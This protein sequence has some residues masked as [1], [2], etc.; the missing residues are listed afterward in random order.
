MK[1]YKSKFENYENFNVLETNKPFLLT[2]LEKK[3]WDTDSYV[4]QIYFTTP[5]IKKMN[6]FCLITFRPNKI[7]CDFLNL[8]I[9]YKMF[10]IVDDNNFDLHD[11]KNNYKNI[12]FIQIEEIKCMNHGFIDT[13]FMINKLV[14]GWD[15]A[16]YYFSI[17]YTDYE[18]IWFMEDDVFFYNENTIIKIDNQYINDDLLSNKYSVNINGN[19]DTWHWGR[20]NI[21][22]NPPYYNGMMCAV[23]FSKNMIKC[24]I[25][26][27]SKNKTLFFLEA[28]FPTIAIKNNLKYSNPVE[29][30][31]IHYRHD[32]E[33]KNI[34]DTDLYHPVKNLNDHLY[35]R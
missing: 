23:R 17:E 33:K 29:F 26:Y 1:Y 30:N 15:K 27:A 5:N 4:R 12:T 14:S 18:F 32:F 13:N 24:I 34:N 8:F 19:R 7:W 9:K 25:D 20:I 21:K 35:F 10:I 31:N 11:F 3:D 16:L 28:L 6:V 2:D 22:Y